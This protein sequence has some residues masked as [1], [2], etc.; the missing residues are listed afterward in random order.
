MSYSLFLDDERHPKTE[1]EF[2]IVRS[3]G[4]AVAYVK[5]HGIPEYIS[6]DH[7]LGEVDATGIDY[8]GY[9]FAKW[10]CEHIIE[11]E[12]QM[13]EWNVHSA[14]PIGAQNINGYLQQFANFYSK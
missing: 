14:N 5:K 7:D 6:F 4:E 1:R 9:T 12:G 13:F 10:I 3:Y 8:S 11:T 2:V